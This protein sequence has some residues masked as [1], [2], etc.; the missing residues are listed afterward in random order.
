MNR[1]LF[2]RNVLL[3]MLTTAAVRVWR[4]TKHHPKSNFGR[5]AT[6]VVD[7]GNGTRSRSFSGVSKS[8]TESR[9]SFKVAGTV[10]NVPVQIG[11]RLEAGDLIAELRSRDLRPASTTGAGVISRIAG[12]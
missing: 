9:T 2:P 8:S 11:Q 12:Q 4:L 1:D 6:S 7:A 5:C 10:T 3:L